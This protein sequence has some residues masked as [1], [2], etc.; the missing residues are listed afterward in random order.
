M[1]EARITSILPYPSFLTLR[2]YPFALI[3]PM[4]LP[5]TPYPFGVIAEGV[6]QRGKEG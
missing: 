1:V 4:P 2:M 3:T 6:P 5:L